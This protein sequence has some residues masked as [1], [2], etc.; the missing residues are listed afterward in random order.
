MS[1]SPVSAFSTTL[2]SGVTLS[3]QI[4]LGRGWE[5]ITVEIPTMASGTDVYFQGAGSDG[6]T[7]RRI[8]HRLT[9]S[10]DSPGAMN[11]DSSVTN[12]FVHLEFVNTK[13]LKI[14]LSTAM[15]ATSAIFGVV[16]A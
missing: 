7:Y 2:A 16:C 9:N 11:V 8:H 6:G 12:C 13:Y 1:Y 10:N 15:T 3:S 5:H 4:D 14:E